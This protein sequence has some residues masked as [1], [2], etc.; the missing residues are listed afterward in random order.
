[1]K[2]PKIDLEITHL[3]KYQHAFAYFT[4]TMCWLLSFRKKTPNRKYTIV[5]ACII[6]GIILEV[7]QYK[8]TQYRTG[9][10]LDILAN[11]VGVVLGLL[12]F[13]QILKKKRIN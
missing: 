2:P 6:F 5:F 4:L 8:L 3:D 7:L 12:I 11:T 9:D 13:N 1:M 10:Y